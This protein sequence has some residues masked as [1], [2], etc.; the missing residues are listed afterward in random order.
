MA[1]INVN[2]RKG[3]GRV[4]SDV[5]FKFLSHEALQPFSPTFKTCNLSLLEEIPDGDVDHLA[6]ISP[7]GLLED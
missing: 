2:E 5:G 3:P 6:T 7:H 4:T 1:D